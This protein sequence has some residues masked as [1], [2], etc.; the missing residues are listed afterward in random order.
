MLAPAAIVTISL[1]RHDGSLQ[2][3]GGGA[4]CVLRIHGVSR[5]YFRCPECGGLYDVKARQVAT[6]GHV[7]FGTVDG[8]F[9]FCQDALCKFV[10]GIRFDNWTPPQPFDVSDAKDPAC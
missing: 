1:Q 8:P 9:F 2:T 4:W 5:A 10:R 3:L 7:D 6:D